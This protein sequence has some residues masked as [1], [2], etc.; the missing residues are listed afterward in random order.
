MK[1]CLNLACRKG[2]EIDK[3][4]GSLA[5]VD[6]SNRRCP[7]GVSPACL[8]IKQGGR[9]LKRMWKDNAWAEP[10]QLMQSDSFVSSQPS[11]GGIKGSMR[12]GPT[13]CS[14]SHHPVADGFAPARIV[15]DGWG[16]KRWPQKGRCVGEE[17]RPG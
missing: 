12:N 4:H 1:G 16:A 13:N 8:T 6:C 2:G 9:W 5:K 14:D 3:R 11:A 7:V 10:G 17:G 15:G